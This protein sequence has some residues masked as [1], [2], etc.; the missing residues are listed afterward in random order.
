MA[1]SEFATQER[2]EALLEVLRLRGYLTINDA[3]HVGYHRGFYQGGEARKAK[4]D[5]TTLA[6]R[7]Q[8]RR[9]DGYCRAMTPQERKRAKH[10]A[11]YWTP[12]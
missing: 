10:W 3:W 12:R 11:D 7:N 4:A 9:H 1:D 5:L 2:Q 6:G 8:A